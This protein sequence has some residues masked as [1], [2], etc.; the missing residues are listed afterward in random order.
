MASSE[1]ISRRLGLTHAH[2]AVKVE[3]DLM[4]ILPRSTWTDFSHRVILHGRRIC[5]ARKPR[6]EVC[7]LR[8]GCPMRQDVPKPRKLLDKKALTTP[9]RRRR[10]RRG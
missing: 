9:R 4:S 2:D 6:C 1:R 10:A 8:E 5:S 3:K 7:N